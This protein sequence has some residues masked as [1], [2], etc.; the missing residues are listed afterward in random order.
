MK[1]TYNILR[2]RIGALSLLFAIIVAL[3]LGCNNDDDFTVDNRIAPFA[4]PVIN[5]ITPNLSDVGNDVVIDGRNFSRLPSNNRVRF[6]DV[7]A[8]V[9]AATDSTLTVEV[10]EGATTGPISISLAQFTVTGPVFMVVP[11]PDITGVSTFIGDVGDE[12]IIEG[13]NFSD[14][15]AENMVLFGTL[16]ATVTAATTDALTV[17]VPDEALTGRI[18]VTVFGQSDTFNSGDFIVAPRIS[19]IDPLSA[20]QEAEITISGAN[21]STVTSE[22]IVTI[23]GV[24]APLVSS[25]LSTITALVPL[26]ALDPGLITV[27]V[28][29]QTAT[30]TQIFTPIV[31]GTSIEVPIN[32]VEDDVEEAADGRMSLDSSDLELG[33]FD[34]SGT[35]DLGL[36]NIGLRFNGVAIPSGV[37]ILSASVQFVADQTEGADPTEMTIYGENVGNAAMYTETI[38]DL[39]ARPLTS[40]SA[41]WNIPEWTGTEIGANQR[42]VDI[43]SII[44]EIIDRG[45]WASGNS[46]NIMLFPSGV[47]AGATENNVGREAETYDVDNPEEGA[48]LII[49]FQ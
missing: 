16:P 23:S 33:E 28:E 47:S 26:D 11:E 22:N 48:R 5:G 42:T 40:A 49:R 10:P 44:Q 38:G 21:F 20:E 31:V 43:S 17:I 46:I 2:T 35:P 30:S 41:I 29:G 24:D 1:K 8:S 25:T 18:S 45:D 14:V 4:E 12:V 13:E 3:F 27:T 6:N 39:S 32:A 34:T 37:T 7:L 9:S 36:Q 15:P 19:S